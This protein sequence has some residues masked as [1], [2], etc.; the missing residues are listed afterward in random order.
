MNQQSN[1]N[2]I[3]IL[4]D[5]FLFIVSS[6]LPFGA[7]SPVS[8]GEKWLGTGGQGFPH[9]IVVKN[10]PANAGNARDASWSLGQKDSMEKEMATHSSTLAWKIPWTESLGGYTIVLGVAKSWTRLGTQE[11]TI[12]VISPCPHIPYKKKK[13]FQLKEQWVLSLFFTLKSVTH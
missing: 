9:S 4:D 11:R 6:S 7:A 2:L 8:H 10:L 13:K 5:W 3:R 12:R 1:D